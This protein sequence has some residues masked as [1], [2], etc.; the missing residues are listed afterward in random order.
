M[1][2]KACHHLAHD[3]HSESFGNAAPRLFWGHGWG[4][5][6][7]SLEPL[8]RALEKMGTHILV[9]FPGFGRSPAPPTAWDTAEYADAIAEYI[10]STGPGKIIWIGHSFGCRVGLQLAAR[11]PDLIAGLFL[12]AGA[13]LPLKRPFLQK[14]YMKS[15]IALYKFLKK[16]IP[17]G[18][19]EDWL[20]S[21]FGSRDYRNANPAMRD[22]L[23]KVI[24]EDLSAQAAQVQC[25]VVLIY[26]AKDTETPPEIG[27]RLNTLIKNSEL[28]ILDG[29][30]HYT[31]LGEGR[32]VV[33]QRLNR[34][35]QELSA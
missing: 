5:S 22:I 19:P 12:I 18:L 15:R 26:G 29:F 11:H 1:K 4:Q 6:L 30:D 24:N 21:K 31:I 23:V 33:T 20:K 7:Q 16:L 10:Q 35:I 27:E 17:L 2:L 9:D 28:I 25:P 13:G 32:H 3:I 34:F 14:I 8:A